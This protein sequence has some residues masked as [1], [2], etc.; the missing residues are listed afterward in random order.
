MEFF[1]IFNCVQQK[2]RPCTSFNLIQMKFHRLFILF[3]TVLSF[4]VRSQNP[5]TGIPSPNIIGPA[6]P[7]ACAGSSFS[8]GL[9]LPYTSTGITYQWQS[10][11]V[12]P[13]GPFTS[14]SGATLSTL[15]NATITTSTYFNV[16]ITCTNSGLSISVNTSVTLVPCTSPCNGVPASN[17]ITAVSQTFC[18]GSSASLTLLNTYTNTGITY[19]WSAST[20]QA[21]PYN[22]IP[23]AT[24]N[25]F[26]SPTLTTTTYF[27]VLITCTNSNQTFSTTQAITV[28]TCTNCFGAP[29]VNSV[30]PSSQ[31]ICAGSSV[32]LSLVN[33]Y[34]ASGITYQWQSS[35]VSPAGPFTSIPGAT[36]SN[37]T[38]PP[39]NAPL[40]YN[41]V[42][43]CTSSGISINASAS[44]YLM[45]CNAP[46]TGAPGS[47]SIIP[48]SQ[49]VCSGSQA[50]LALA[51]TFSVSGLSYQWYSSSVLAGPYAAIPGATLN[52]LVSPSLSSAQFYNLVITCTNSAQSTTLSAQVAVVNCSPCVG[53][54]GTNTIVPTNS[55]LCY[56]SPAILGLAQS[57]TNPA[58]TYQW[59]SGTI[60]PVGPFTSI[61]SATLSTLVSPTLY[62]S[63]YFNVIITCTSSGASFSTSQM[64]SVV[65]CVGV[66]EME[67]KE[68]Q[69]SLIPNPASEL[70][71]LVF[72]VPV[73][74]VVEVVDL[75][76]RLIY[77]SEISGH[78][79]ELNLG[80]WSKGLYFLRFSNQKGT[81]TLKLIKD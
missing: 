58:V 9:L 20:I 74:G 18:S 48:S 31:T 6:S 81:Q 69:L 56:G 66:S 67:E 40:F 62:V 64:I 51:N 46:C 23:G 47:N 4:Q 38:S 57:Y 29:A 79:F 78:V 80:G 30:V 33:T 21:G 26:V 42:I 53:I 61:N 65:Q 35:T 14:I 12:S 39:L 2:L 17:T 50:S 25:S 76:S 16:I 8:L 32:S 24:L 5:C 52:T 70:V 41:V 63:T 22:N 36:L 54:P 37:Y 45:I 19:Q 75:S 49:T 60:S 34:S 73:D 11:T 71:H 13:V 77:H 28:I 44:V 43:T 72:T 68:N 7:T 10:S 1:F 55:V 3:C 59:Q 27:G 15:S